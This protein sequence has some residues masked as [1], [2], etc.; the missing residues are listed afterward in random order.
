MIIKEFG[1]AKLIRKG[2]FYN[3][4]I[5]AMSQF[6]FLSQSWKFLCF[7]EIYD[8]LFR[9]FLFT[10]TPRQTLKKGYTRQEIF[11]TRA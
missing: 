11:S 9:K 8:V 1:P 6:N 3:L 5:K 7:P 2:Q 10:C 4:F